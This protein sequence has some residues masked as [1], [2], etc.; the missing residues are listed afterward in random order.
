MKLKA[1]RYQLKPN[2]T[3]AEKFSQAF[4]HNRF[5]WN[6]VLALKQRYYRMFGKSVSKRR[7]QDQLVKNKKQARFD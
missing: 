6:W 1:Y 3:Q 2:K 7:L 4:S 5:V